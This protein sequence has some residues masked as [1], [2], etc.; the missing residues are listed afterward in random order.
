MIELGIKLIWLC[1]GVVAGLILRTLF[2]YWQRER[3]LERIF[4]RGFHIV[5]T[6]TNKF[7]GVIEMIELKEGQRV[8][9][10]VKPKTAHGN[11]ANIEPGSARWST[12]DE[13]IVGVTPDPANELSAYFEC[14]DGSIPQA[15]GTEFRADGKVGEGVR[16]IIVAGT[17]GVNPGDAMFAEME[18]G[19]VEDVPPPEPQPENVSTDTTPAE[20]GSAEPEPTDSGEA[21]ADSNE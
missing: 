9:A 4:N 3:Q 19:E 2:D 14:L 6:D 21:V 8:K 11:P 20:T 13:S 15:I 17:I 12:G 7:I 16:D 10:T 18:F 5:E 1:V